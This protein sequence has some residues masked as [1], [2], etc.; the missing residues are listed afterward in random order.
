MKIQGP[1]LSNINA[2]KKMYHTRTEVKHKEANKEDKVNISNEAK[3][4]QVGTQSTEERRQYVENI[5]QQV[6]TGQ[7]QV[8]YEQTARKMI[9][10]WSKRI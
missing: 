1:N 6:Q 9:E 5:K 2:Y 10:Y 4:L 3:Q 8:N 7:Y